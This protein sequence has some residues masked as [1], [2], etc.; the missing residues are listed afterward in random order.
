MRKM[1][2]YPAAHK[3]VRGVAH[4]T[5]SVQGKRFPFRRSGPNVTIVGRWRG[6][7]LGKAPHCR[8]CA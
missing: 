8:G 6:V 1:I 2:G 5:Q 3:T 4:T 7:I